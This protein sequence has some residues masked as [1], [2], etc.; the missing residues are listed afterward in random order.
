MILFYVFSCNL[1]FKFNTGFGMIIHVDRCYSSSFLLIIRITLY[2]TIYPLSCSRILI[3]FSIFLLKSV[4]QLNL[5]FSSLY[6]V[7]CRSSQARDRIGATSASLHHSNSNAGSKLSL[8]PTQQLRATLYNP[9][10]E[11]RDR[12]NILMDTSRVLNL[13]SLDGNVWFWFF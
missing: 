12:T 8:Q 9:L 5:F 2:T 13:L 11:V 7:A 3:W 6:L 1:L 4:L 10:S